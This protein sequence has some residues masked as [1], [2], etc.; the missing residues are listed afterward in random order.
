M[1]Q[2]EARLKKLLGGV[3]LRGLHTPRV[4]SLYG[5]PCARV[6]GPKRPTHASP[7]FVAVR[8]SG[9]GRLR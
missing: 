3:E 6:R 7:I 5:D 9:V 8:P 1:D 2:F 4:R